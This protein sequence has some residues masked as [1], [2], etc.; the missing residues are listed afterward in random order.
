VSA[1]NYTLVQLAPALGSF[2]LAMGLAGWLYERAL[3]RHG[4]GSNNCVGQDCFGTTFLILAAL[5]GVATGCMV[6]LCRRNMRLYP[7][8]AEEVG[9]RVM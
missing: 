2:G 8:F 6:Q 7:S 3:S 4:G 9:G 1:A 5:G